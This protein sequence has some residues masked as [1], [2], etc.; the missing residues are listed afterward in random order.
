[1]KQPFR[2][3]K[4]GITFK[5]LLING[6]L[7]IAVGVIIIGIFYSYRHVKSALTEVFD[8][9]AQAMVQN[10]HIG[11]ELTLVL[12]DTSY[13]VSAFY[14]ND[15]LLNNMGTQLIIRLKDLQK[16]VKN[17]RLIKS[18]K[19]FTLTIRM[20]LEQ[21]GRIN[22]IHRKL[23]SLRADFDATI[24]ALDK[25]V[26]ARLLDLMLKGEDVTPLQQ[27]TI[28]IP[29]LHESFLEINLHL[30]DIGLEHFEANMGKQQHPLLSLSDNLYLR[31]LSLTSPFDTISGYYEQLKKSVR[32]YRETVAQLHPAARTFKMRRV[33]LEQMKETL[34]AQLEEIDTRMGQTMTAT[35]QT[36]IAKIEKGAQIGITVAFIVLISISIFVFW[37]GK[38]ITHSINRVVKRFKDIAAGEGD[39]TVSLADNARDETGALAHQFNRF[40]ANLREMIREIAGN[41]DRLNRFAGDLSS[42]SGR[43]SEEVETVSSKSGQVATTAEDMSVKINTMAVATEEINDNISAISSATEQM[44]QNMNSAA[45]SI[46]EMNTVVS[47]ISE[48]SQEG[49][50]MTASAQETAQIASD[51]MNELNDAVNE[52]GA[53]IDVIGQIATRTNLLAL[54]ARIEAA[55]AGNAGKG[56]AVVADEI[57]ALA[58]RSAEAA[59]EVTD[60]IESVQKRTGNAIKVFA[61]LSEIIRT[62]NQR[63]SDIN[64]AVRQQSQSTGEISAN[65][66]QADAGISNISSSI[67]GIAFKISEMSEDA[68]DAADAA[69]DVAKNILAVSEVSDSSNSNARKVSVSADEMAQVAAQLQKLV[70]RFK[71]DKR[72]IR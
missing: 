14:R 59:S 27:L 55:S 21:C 18:L 66:L 40:I 17:K 7:Y 43:M 4:K 56:F 8:H 61:D 10:A 60:H 3:T 68:G 2:K 58:V 70:D 6:M 11:R 12:A 69:I 34:L 72:S 20:V 54:N 29:E 63:I 41:A 25:E 62:V 46:E 37:L 44:S 1:M 35:A 47:A 64:S 5:L 50:G 9:H 57:K 31:L 13:L 30:F 51:A 16:R 42:V 24:D 26:A 22:Q 71:I 45:S 52:I 53:I 38:T 19:N 15:E 32:L 39:L 33:A 65:M 23:A 28:M 36:M 48:N 49:A 67:T